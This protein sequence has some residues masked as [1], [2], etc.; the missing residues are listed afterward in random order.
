[1][2]QGLYDDLR[3]VVFTVTDVSG[4]LRGSREMPPAVDYVCQNSQ[5]LGYGQ[6]YPPY[7][8]STQLVRPQGPSQLLRN[9]QPEDHWLPQRYMYQPGV[10]QKQSYTTNDRKMMEVRKLP[11]PIFNKI[12]VKLN[13]K[14][15]FFDDFRMVGEELGVDRD[16]IEIAGQNRN[17]SEFIFSQ[18]CPN[19]KVHELVDVL[20]KIERMD[21]AEE[22]KRWITEG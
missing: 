13:I 6:H 19:V 3:N 5:N 14:R 2:L 9:H 16:T 18:C 10:D 17:P 11:Y 1:M 20:Q 7:V 15:D 8:A 22:L 4:V 12:C 21:V